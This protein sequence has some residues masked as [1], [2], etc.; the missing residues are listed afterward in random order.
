MS[1]PAARSWGAAWGEW[2]F[3]FHFSH[4]LCKDLV[5]ASFSRQAELWSSCMQLANICSL[6]FVSES[7][8]LQPTEDAASRETEAGITDR[9][10]E[11]SLCTPS[12][13]SWMLC[14]ISAPT[15]PRDIIVPLNRQEDKDDERYQIHGGCSDPAAN[16]CLWDTQPKDASAAKFLFLRVLARKLFKYFYDK[17]RGKLCGQQGGWLTLSPRSL[18]PFSLTTSRKIHFKSQEIPP[19]WQLMRDAGVKILEAAA[20]IPL[21]R[22][23]ACTTTLTFYDRLGEITSLRSARKKCGCRD[24]DALE[25]P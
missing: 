9:G 17:W 12:A 25:L 2:S 19:D 15:L 13:H 22:S 8:Y 7:A 3:Q 20:E 1:T 4:C 6:S 10:L 14:P 18:L 11:V 24:S 16:T 21:N 5:L 23:R